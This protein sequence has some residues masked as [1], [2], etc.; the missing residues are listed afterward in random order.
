MYCDFNKNAHLQR[1]TV[2]LA[3]SCLLVLFEY[4]DP[5]CI[6]IILPLFDMVYFGCRVP[7]SEKY[8][9]NLELCRCGVFIWVEVGEIDICGRN[10]YGRNTCYMIYSSFL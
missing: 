6:N 4:L 1:V 10:I 9:K 7:F 2:S 5:L 8:D 3:D